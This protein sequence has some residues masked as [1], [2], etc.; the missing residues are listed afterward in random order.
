MR[1]EKEVLMRGSKRFLVGILLVSML[2]LCACGGTGSRT[3]QDSSS[4]L[5]E[6]SYDS[7]ISAIVYEDM[8]GEGE[9]IQYR[10]VTDYD[11]LIAYSLVPVCLY[12][13]AG[14]AADT[15]GTSAI[16]EQIAENFHGQILFVAID[17][18]QEKDLVSHFEIEAL[19]DFILLDDGNLTASFSSYDGKKWT[20]SDLEEWV[21]TRSGIS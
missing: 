18:E 7:P 3:L 8:E 6:Y 4:Y 2:F 13:Y 21:I 1:P 14:L 12:F 20:Q 11:Q 19:P 16:V 10:R 9:G 5:G 17:A 15:S